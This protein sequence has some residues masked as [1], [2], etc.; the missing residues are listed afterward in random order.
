MVNIVISYALWNTYYIAFVV[1]I[2]IF[3]SGALSDSQKTAD[4]VFRALNRTKDESIKKMLKLFADQIHHTPMSF[5][6]RLFK[7]DWTL[8]YTFISASVMYVV[9]LIQFEPAIPQMNRTI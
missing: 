1:V 6:C 4:L 2:I 7:F 3:G 9:I 5:S 8:L